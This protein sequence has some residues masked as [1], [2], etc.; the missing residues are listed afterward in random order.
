MARSQAEKARTREKILTEAAAQIR[1]TGLESVSVA[2]LMQRVDLTHGGFY[3]HFASRA[4]LLVEAL[5]R[6]LSDGA[7]RGRALRDPARAPDFDAFVK[8]Y[9][10]RGH[11]DARKAGCALA[12][13]ASD[14][15]RAEAPSRAV[16]HARFEDFVTDLARM[17][18]PEH[19]AAVPAEIHA[20]AQTAACTL[21]GALLMSRVITDSRQ[22][23][24]LLKTV[25][26]QLITDRETP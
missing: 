18:A 3:N 8:Q 15:A 2:G 21:I 20:Q 1:D 12:A 11:R 7:A 17:L 24:A 22:S 19:G 5:A 16:M 4:E 14:V 23:D 10:S 25:R 6:A 13:L 9:L 26:Q